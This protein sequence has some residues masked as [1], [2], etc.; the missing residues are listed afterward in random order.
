MA[1]KIYI[2][3]YGNECIIIRRNYTGEKGL[4]LIEYTKKNKG[5]RYVS[6]INDLTEI[7]CLE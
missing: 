2:D 5:T 7:N 4:C 1:K 3:E 6:F